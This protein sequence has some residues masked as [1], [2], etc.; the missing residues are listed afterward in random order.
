MCR[1]IRGVRSRGVR[2]AIRGVPEVNIIKLFSG[3]LHFPLDKNTTLFY[4]EN[5]PTGQ[6]KP[7]KDRRIKPYQVRFTEAENKK[8]RD[9]AAAKHTDLSELIRQVLHEKVD[10]S[11]VAA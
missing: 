2:C 9:F 10:S 3:Y 6:I 1:A 4:I 11:Q 7:K 5:M 8:F